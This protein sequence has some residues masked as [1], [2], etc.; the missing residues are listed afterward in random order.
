MA[1]HI[2]PRYLPHSSDF[3][4]SLLTR[5]KILANYTHIRTHVL[6]AEGQNL[7]Q[8]DAQQLRNKERD[9]LEN[10]SQRLDLAHN[11]SESHSIGNGSCGWIRTNNGCTDHQSVTKQHS[12]IHSPR[13]QRVDGIIALMGLF[14][15]PTAH[16]DHGNRAHRQGHTRPLTH[17]H[18]TAHKRT[19]ARGSVVRCTTH[20]PRCRSLDWGMLRLLSDQLYWPAT[21]SLAPAFSF[22]F[23]VD[24]GIFDYENTII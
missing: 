11:D 2:T 17:H 16:R 4:S 9:P 23:A 8:P 20:P 14:I 12:A 19:R 18:P 21:P 3:I 24:G 22:G 10:K 7:S 13:L 15:E 6:G 1:G 5:C